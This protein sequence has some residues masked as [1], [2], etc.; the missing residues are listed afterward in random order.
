MTAAVAA[1]DGDADEDKTLLPGNWHAC[2]DV[3]FRL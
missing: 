1:D 2:C 3:G